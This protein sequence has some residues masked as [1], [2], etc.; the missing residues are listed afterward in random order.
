[1]KKVLFINLSTYRIYDTPEKRPILE[2]LWA[3]S[4]SAMLP[5]HE[6]KIFDMNLYDN[7]ED[8]I[9]E[10]NPDFVGVSIVTPLLKESKEVISIVRKTTFAKIII[11]GPH[12]SIFHGKNIDCDFAVVGEG[13]YTIQDIIN[14]TVEKKIIISEK[15]KDLNKLPFPKRENTS[16]YPKMR[17]M[18]ISRSCPYRCV[19]CASKKIFGNKMTFRN[20]DNIIDELKMLKKEYNISYIIFLDDCFTLVRNR[21]IELCQRLIN[22]DINI[23]WW[24]DTR[25]DK[26]D[27]ELLEIMKK[28]GCSNIVFGV[29]S[30]NQDV[31]NRIKKNLK[32]PD[33]E[34]AFKLTKEVGIESKCNMMIGHLDET[35]DE[36]MDSIN[37]SRKL[38]ATKSSFYKVIPLPGSELYEICIERNLIT[39][40]ESEFESMAWYKYP[41]IISKVSK[42]RLEELQKLA[43]EIA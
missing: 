29:E 39:G 18:F 41:P 22:E 15:I 30:G 5:E 25:C 24:I 7:L 21:I 2:P 37:L 4:L 42:E 13:E 6:T 40:D 9:N 32:I 28:A 12:V 14:G 16:S 27:K 11:G 23:K 31:L 33:I 38:K 3:E 36:I 8:T 19:Y 17:S 10:F 1:M 43:Y 35:E 34:N 26:I 20:V